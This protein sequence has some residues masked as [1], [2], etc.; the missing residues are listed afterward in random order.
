MVP[1]SLVAEYVAFYSETPDAHNDTPVV[2]GTGPDTS[3]CR[4]RKRSYLLILLHMKPLDDS[5]GLP[6]ANHLSAGIVLG[7]HNIY[8][9]IPQFVSTL[10]TSLIFTAVESIA[11]DTGGTPGFSA[12]SNSDAYGW[13]LRIGAIASMISAWMAWRVREV[14]KQ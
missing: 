7:I 3:A 14:R 1:F 13:C 10:I 11:P 8:I 12:K 6:P 2:E 4:M 9:V 5:H